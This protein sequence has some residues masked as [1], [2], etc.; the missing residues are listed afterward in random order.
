M[1]KHHAD[2]FVQFLANLEGVVQF[3]HQQFFLRAQPVRL[4][5]VDGREVAGSH[6]IFLS[7]HHHCSLLEVYLFEESAFLHLPF[8]VFLEELTFYLKLDYGDGL[9]HQGG[10]SLCLLVHGCSTARHLRLELLAGVVAV[11]VH[12]KGGKWDEVDAVSF[13]QGSQVGIAQ[14]ET[15]NVADAGIVAGSCSHPEHVVVTPL[16]IPAVIAA[17][18]VEDDMCAWTTVVDVAQ[19]MELVDGK[20]LDN[21][22]D[23]YDEVVGTPCT[24]DGVYDDVDVSCLVMVFS[25]LMQEFLDDVG[26]VA[27]QRLAHLGTGVFARYITAYSHQLVEGDVIPVVNVSFSLFHLFQHLFRIIDESAELTFILFAQ[28][29]A[30]EFVHLAL[31]VS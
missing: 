16:H 17:H 24:D 1:L 11:G 8:R 15:D 3:L 9:V 6:L 26:E 14:R 21:V 28:R 10:E 4:F 7:V 25:M 27:W 13:F 12:R 31:D 5:R 23:G 30:E 19:N 29:V 18:L 2:M 22:G 20:A